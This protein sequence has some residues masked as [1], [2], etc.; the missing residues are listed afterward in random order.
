[1]RRI[2]EDLGTAA[3]SLYRYV[4]GKTTYSRSW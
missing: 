1:M 4:D 2:A 3:A